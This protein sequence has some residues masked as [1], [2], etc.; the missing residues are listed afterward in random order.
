[1]SQECAV[2]RL[3]PPYRDG[4]SAPDT[5]AAS[6]AKAPSRRAGCKPRMP[7]LNTGAGSAYHWLRPG[8]SRPPTPQGVGAPPLTNQESPRREDRYTFPMP[9]VACCWRSSC[10]P[11][12]SP[13]L[14]CRD[15]TNQKVN[16]CHRPEL[17]LSRSIPKRVQIGSDFLQRP[18]LS[19]NTFRD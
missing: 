9:V 6:R 12:E 11:H 19:T 18:T 15:D 17:T 16:C 2:S 5:L 8:T 4:R 10:L 13:S 7:E 1:M 3:R 14:P